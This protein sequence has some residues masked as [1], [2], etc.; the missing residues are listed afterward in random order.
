MLLVA[1]QEENDLTKKAHANAQE[2]NEELSKEV[3][4]ADGKIK[5]LS[6]TVQR[7]VFFS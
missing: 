7:F 6:D 3:E 4:D 2:R 5:Q 1:E